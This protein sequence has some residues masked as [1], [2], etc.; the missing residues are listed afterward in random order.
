MDNFSG[1]DIT[2]LLNKVP[3]KSIFQCNIQFE[4]LTCSYGGKVPGKLVLV[5]HVSEQISQYVF[6]KGDV[7]EIIGVKETG[8][9]NL[10]LS[11]EVNQMI[12]YETVID[13]GASLITEQYLIEILVDE[14]GEVE[15]D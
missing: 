4:Y 9:A 2:L 8:E 15:N 6:K 5:G 14:Q 12:H 11:C 10:F 7:L 1:L 3:L 13:F